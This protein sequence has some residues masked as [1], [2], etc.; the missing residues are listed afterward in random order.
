MTFFAG[1]G[2]QKFSKK[3]T[4]KNCNI[5]FKNQQDENFIFQRV[6]FLGEVSYHSKMLRYICVS[7]PPIVDRGVEYSTHFLLTK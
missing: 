2:L 4:K 5:S 1:D 3:K 7:C 6:N